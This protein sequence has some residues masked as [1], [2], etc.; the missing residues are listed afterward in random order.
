MPN[1]NSAKAPIAPSKSLLD[2]A[3]K[4][5]L[6][7]RTEVKRMKKEEVEVLV[8]DLQLHQAELDISIEDLREIQLQ[9]AQARDRYAELYDNAPMAYLTLDKNFVV[10]QA[11][12]TAAAIFDRPRDLLEGKIFPVF[13]TPEDRD[14]CHVHFHSVKPEKAGHSVIRFLRTDNDVFWGRLHTVRIDAPESDEPEF[15]VAL[16]DITN[17]KRIEELSRSN[18]ELENF[19]KL[20]VNRE[21]RMIELKRE[22]DSLCRQLGQ[23]SRY[24]F[25]LDPVPES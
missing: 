1:D 10:K 4:R 6:S 19:N 12:N 16:I 17:E 11:N 14:A 5:M 8:C 3:R 18:R 9:L 25:N 15:R 20:M 13:A 2:R 23:P 22:V 7:N 21:L 24:G